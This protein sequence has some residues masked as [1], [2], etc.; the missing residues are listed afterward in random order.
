MY[1]DETPFTVVLHFVLIRGF[2]KLGLV[3]VPDA[4][5]MLVFCPVYILYSIREIQQYVNVFK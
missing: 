3:L 2:D 5:Y 1:I 4:V